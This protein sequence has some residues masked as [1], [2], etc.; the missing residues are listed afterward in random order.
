MIIVE[1]RNGRLITA[2]RESLTSADV[3]YHLS[4]VLTGLYSLAGRPDRAIIE[5]RIVRHAA[6]EKIAMDGTPDIRLVVYRGIPAMAMVRLPTKASQGRANLHQGA[7]AAGVDLVEGRTIGG[8]CR[9][10]PIEHHPDTKFPLAG[11]IIPFWERIIEAGMRLAHGL[12][13]GYLG[14]DFVLDEKRG[15]LVLEANARPGLG[16]Q[17]ANRCGL[18]ERL[19]AIDALLDQRRPSDPGASPR[20]DELPRDSFSGPDF[21]RRQRPG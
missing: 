14:I 3:R 10:R 6:F 4:A 17:L 9:S 2:G 16:I 21:I 7:A 12:E 19:H 1:H 18:V 8:I 11:M 15:P 13:L 20:T 5:Q